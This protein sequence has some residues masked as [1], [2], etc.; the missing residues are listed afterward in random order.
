MGNPLLPENISALLP[1]IDIKDA[2][3]TKE[4]NNTFEIKEVPS[5]FSCYSMDEITVLAGTFD[6]YNISV[7]EILGKIYYAP[8]LL[9]LLTRSDN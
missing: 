3:E 4:I 1:V 7:A 6:S 2:L 8:K 5:I 9:D